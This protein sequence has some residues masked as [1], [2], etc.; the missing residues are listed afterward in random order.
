MIYAFALVWEQLPEACLYMIGPTDEDPEYYQECQELIQS[1]GVDGISFV[2]RVNVAEWYGKLD[3]VLLSSISEG[4]PFV[5]LEAMASRRPVVATDVGSCRELLE[6]IDDGLGPAGEIV[7]VMS[8]HFMA[9]AVLQL[10]RDLPALQKMGENGRNR[11][12]RFYREEVFL[13]AYRD[14]YGEVSSHGRRRI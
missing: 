3:L 13:K 14:L 1:L 7:P 6:G 9:K 10:A 4:Q 11:V 8:P 12:D 5:V 2:G